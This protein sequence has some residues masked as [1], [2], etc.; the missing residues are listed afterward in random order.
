MVLVDHEYLTGRNLQVDPACEP[1]PP[2]LSLSLVAALIL[3]SLVLRSFRIRP[4][5]FSLARFVPLVSFGRPFNGVWKRVHDIAVPGSIRAA[6]TLSEKK[7]AA[8]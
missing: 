7:A 5:F 8:F 2:S 4:R 3:F 1:V 6:S